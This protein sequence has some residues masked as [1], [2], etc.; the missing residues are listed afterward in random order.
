[1]KKRVFL[2]I[3]LSF[4]LCGCTANVNISIN[5]D[6]VSERITITE[7]TYDGFSINDIAQQYRK[8]VPAFYD[9][10]VIDTMPDVKEEGVSYYGTS[11][12]SS[13]NTF[14]ALYQHD[15]KFKEYKNARTIRNAFKSSQVQYDPYEKQVLFTSEASGMTLFNTYPQ[16]SEVRINITTNYLV[17]ETN[18]DYHNGNVYTWVF[19]KDTKKGVYMLLSDPDGKSIGGLNNT[20]N[21]N[22]KKDEEVTDDKKDDNNTNNQSN[23][24]SNNQTTNED[25][26]SLVEKYGKINT[27]TTEKEKNPYLFIIIIFAGFVVLFIVSMKVKK[28]D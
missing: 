23:N 28:D 19:N 5:G 4:L 7:S 15:F 8:Y 25:K 2:L 14:T 13:G 20:T 21:N 22:D 26:G 6:T 24:Q 17:M 16:L 3:L 18:A 1:M 11:G 12:S 10:P 9:V 27:D